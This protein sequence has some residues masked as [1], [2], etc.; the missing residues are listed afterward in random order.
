MSLTFLL[1]DMWKN[2]FIFIDTVN[3]FNKKHCLKGKKNITDI[4]Y[5]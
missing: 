3:A 1:K 2:K 4:K 5:N